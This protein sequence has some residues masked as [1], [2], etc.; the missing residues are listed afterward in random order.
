M[1]FDQPFPH[2][3]YY[4]LRALLASGNKMVNETVKILLFI[5]LF[6]H[7]MH[8]WD[9]SSPIRDGT[10]APYTGSTSLNHWTAREVSMGKEFGKE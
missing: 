9:L 1:S 3:I 10:H 2:S 6:G 5:S 4:L 7:A 8:M